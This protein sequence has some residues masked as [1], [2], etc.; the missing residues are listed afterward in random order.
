MKPLRLL[1]L[2][3]A[4]AG[5]SGCDG[6][7]DACFFPDVGASVPP[8]GMILVGEQTTVRLSPNLIGGCGTVEAVPDSL[9][10]EVYDPDNQPVAH[11]AGLGAPGSAS[12]IRFTASKPGRHHVFVAFDPVGGIQQ[13]A[14]HAAMDRSREGQTLRLQQG[15]TTLER[16]QKG[17]LV[18][19][20]DV[21]RDGAYVQRFAN[22]TLAV[23]G[24]VVWVV[25]TS[26]IHR[27]VDTGST[28]MLTATVV[29]TTQALPEA[30]HAWE[31]ELVVLT[32][33]MVQRFAFNGTELA[34]T[35]STSWGP[36]NNPIVSGGPRVLT[37]RTG[38]RLGLVSRVATTTFNTPTYQVCPYRLE[39]G[40][41]TRTT[42]SCAPFNGVVVGY[43]PSALWIADTQGFTETNFTGLRYAQWT[44]TGLA[45]Q[46]AL[47][48][49]GNLRLIPRP[50]QSRQTAVP[51]I[52]SGLSSMFSQQLVAMPV[53]SADR[54]AI[55]LEYLGPDLTE[56]TGSVKLIWGMTSGSG[57]SGGTL[58]RVRPSAQ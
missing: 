37:V 38:D 14:L 6:D 3:V 29:A 50:F 21:L 9:S 53:Y 17:A 32:P 19:D 45:E 12:V 47:P 40:R 15:C 5:L 30:L 46:A 8:P 35:G 42:E 25:T 24:D 49:G 54:R 39:A 31:N 2:L 43:E 27:Y 20:L 34:L 58:I 33:S 56:P 26:R 55:L 57:T 28:L 7:E 13:F 41:F 4:L 16:T 1:P 10:V 23:A 11:S 22:S 52:S 51:S 48:L 44:A 36:A 18:C